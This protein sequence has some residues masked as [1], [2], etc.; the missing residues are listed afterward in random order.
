MC[1]TLE[2]SEVLN[3]QLI[4][5]WL[6]VPCNFR[7]V[8]QTGNLTGCLWLTGSNGR[9]W[10][11]KKWENSFHPV[12]HLS[13]NN[14]LKYPKTSKRNGCSS[15][16]RSIHQLLKVRGEN[17]LEWRAIVRKEHLGG[18]KR[19]KKLLEQR[20]MR[21]KPC[22]RT[23]CHLICNLGT[24]RREKRQLRQWRNPRRNHGKNWVVSWIP[25]IFRQT[26]YFGR[27]FVVYVAKNR[28]SRTPS[29][30]LTV[31]F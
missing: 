25:S 2:W 23:D 20:K 12:Y 14:F 4:T 24:L 10:R 16:Q 9:L 26:K 15:D 29:R 13:S 30:I 27:A 3:C 17:R 21:S 28:V 1:W 31:T 11:T 6:Y 8:G 18:I 7:N 22:Y 5:I 19:L